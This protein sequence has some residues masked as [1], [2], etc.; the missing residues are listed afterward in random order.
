MGDQIQNFIKNTVDGGHDDA[1]TTISVVDA[2]EFPD[3]GDG[4]Y[5]VTW[6]DSTNY[7]DPADDPNKELVR[8]TAR[9]TGANTITVTRAQEGTSATNKNTSGA[10]YK[11]L[12]APTKKVMDEKI[13][14][15]SEDELKNKTINGD[16]NDISNIGD[17]SLSTKYIKEDG[18][19][20]L[21]AD[22]DIGAD[23][24]IKGDEI[25]ARDEAGLKLYDDE[26][27]GIF[28]KDG[29]NIG[30]GTTEPSEILDV[31]GNAEL[32]SGSFLFHTRSAALITDK[33]SCCFYSDNGSGSS[34]FSQY[35]NLFIQPRTSNTRS[36]YFNTNDGSSVDHRVVIKSDG[37]VGIGTISPSS[38]LDVNGSLDKNSGSFKIDH[39]LEPTEKFL[40][41]GFVE[42]PRFDLIHR[43]RV[44]LKNGK[45]T[46]NI[47][48][49][50]G[51]TKGTFEAL[52]QNKEVTSL[53][54]VNSFVRVKSTD[55]KNG[56]FTI[57]AEEETK[58]EVNW[59]V[60]AE[61]ADKWIKHTKE[62]DKEGHLVNEINKEEPTGDELKEDKREAETNEEEGETK[63][64]VDMSDKKGF[65]RNPEAHG[66]EKPKRK[67]IRKL[68]KP[69]KLLIK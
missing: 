56:E 28:I 63:E 34:P 3:P 64:N 21:T 26:G 29:G 59:T 50:Y 1:D 20:T 55:I 51:M 7:P 17:S 32:A 36:I 66:Q 6:Y 5:N 61:R 18:S 12:L 45:A 67:I 35:G 11:M 8:V 2:S 68:N 22:W 14:A 4:E 16:D 52:C 39:P 23:R 9:D 46:V 65:Y 38:T 44:K 48:K 24:K 47:D 40:R 58:I 31:N 57:E 37:K 19:R 62:T 43:G 10:T 49:E 41:Y 25:R 27:E 54:A 30:I 42:S 13:E 60:I 33:L 69:L 53:L 15:D